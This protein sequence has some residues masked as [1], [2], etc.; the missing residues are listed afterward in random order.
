MYIIS[1][2]S[3]FTGGGFGGGGNYEGSGFGG[4]YGGGGGGGG[5]GGGGYGGGGSGGTEVVDMEE[6][7]VDTEEEAVDMEEEEVDTTAMVVATLV[8][9]MDPKT[10]AMALLDRTVGDMVEVLQVDHTAITVV[11]VGT[12][13]VE[14]EEAGD[15][16]EIGRRSGHVL[17]GICCIGVALYGG[18]LYE[19]GGLDNRSKN[20]CTHFITMEMM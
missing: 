17:K 4:G 13:V 11:V 16:K 12:A 15:S 14:E 1:S 5:Y 3:L 8:R 2:L 20:E 7:A 9:D 6:E 18:G 19:G 10:Q